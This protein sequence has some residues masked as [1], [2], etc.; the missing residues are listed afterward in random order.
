MPKQVGTQWI[1]QW[2]AGYSNEPVA[3]TQ[4]NSLNVAMP[5]GTVLQLSAATRYSNAAVGKMGEMATEARL[6]AEGLDYATQVTFK[7]ASGITSRPD[8]ITRNEAG[9]LNLLEVKTG[10]APLTDNQ[11]ELFDAIQ[12]GENVIPV[13]QNAEN[14]GLEVGKPTKISNVSFDVPDPPP[15]D[16]GL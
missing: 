3:W 4:N 6:Q 13:G 8:F 1:S 2:R 15:D 16:P 9:E 5:S 10:N 14:F 12:R 11:I 7:T